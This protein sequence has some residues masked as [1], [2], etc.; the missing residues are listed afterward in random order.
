MLGRISLAVVCLGLL[1]ALA[2]PARADDESTF[3]LLVRDGETGTPIA[4]AVAHVVLPDVMRREKLMPYFEEKDVGALAELHGVAV[5]TDR[6]GVAH[7]PRAALTT[8]WFVVQH[9]G[10][11][12]ALSFYD[13]DLEEHHE[14]EIFPDASIR[15]R[16]LGPDGA[17]VA[18][19][20]L[21]LRR[22]SGYGYPFL[23]R[24]ESQPETGEIVI[25]HLAWRLKRRSL[26]ACLA[27]I[28]LPGVAVAA[29]IALPYPADEPVVLRLP[30]TG[31]LRVVPTG[32]GAGGRLRLTLREDPLAQFVPSIEHDVVDGAVHVFPHV[33]L[34]RRYRVDVWPFDRVY[35]P[36]EPFVVD[37]PREAGEEVLA[38]PV[39]ATK[40]VLLV[41]RIVDETG[42]PVGE[43]SFHA[44]SYRG[45]SSGLSG[46]ETDAEGRF[47]YVADPSLSAEGLPFS[48]FVLELT[49]QDR[50]MQGDTKV[51]IELELPLAAGR[52]DLG[53]LVL[54]SAPIVLS[55]VVVDTE[56]EPV[57]E[58]YVFVCQ[59][60]ALTPEE[61]GQRW[62]SP[63]PVASDEKDEDPTYTWSPQLRAISDAD[64]R[65]VMTGELREEQPCRFAVHKP[66][67]VILAPQVARLGADDERVVLE[68]T[69]RL[70]GEIRL[71]P[72]VDPKCLRLLVR[73][74]PAATEALEPTA[75]GSEKPPPDDVGEAEVMPG[76]TVLGQV[77][78]PARDGLQP[79]VF[80]NL[81]PGRATLAICI[82]SDPDPVAEFEDIEI[83]GGKIARDPRFDPFD[84]SA[85]VRSV[86]LAIADH[87]GTLP[88]GLEVRIFRGHGRQS[89]R[90]LNPT[91]P[92]EGGPVE[93]ALLAGIASRL[94]VEVRAPGRRAVYREDVQDDQG[95]RL[96][97]GISVRLA[98]PPGVRGAE[99]TP[100]HVAAARVRDESKRYFRFHTDGQ[101]AT[102]KNAETDA[103]T[104]LLP[105][106]GRWLVTVIVAG[107]EAA[108][109]TIDVRG[110]TKEDAG[111]RVRI[112]AARQV[113]RPAPGSSPDACGDS[114]PPRRRSCRGSPRRR[115]LPCAPR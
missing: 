19:I 16:V 56:G 104:L 42:A 107:N 93:I 15:L 32:E 25:R 44:H 102:V 59:G 77:T 84:A 85:L 3:P 4:G 76:W 64:G 75:W 40:N 74:R 39:V 105:L 17:P 43:T 29:E 73:G 49:P 68:R 12:G 106:P 60:R 20:P 65:F 38:E 89:A 31:R 99:A 81:R 88:A 79:F 62:Y 28:E 22:P 18:G 91:P 5:T 111:L 57:P 11:F 95:I 45:D 109:A 70:E 54:P 27:Q 10:R 50:S 52:T 90:A 13:P 26:S 47:R 114:P 96:E 9:E 14:L 41:G 82:D 51:R 67:Y 36:P 21:T 33:G 30:E 58:V 112:A 34:G 6:H 66:G 2:L 53:D 37:G 35:R 80:T 69:G 55:G 92:A 71:G 101:Y 98:L 86:R 83:V 108:R 63:R 46:V 61:A 7:V 48:A 110:D 113:R 23:W 87:T 97:P 72:W 103:A 78:I 115:A 100:L 94:D 8:G 1:L 24:G